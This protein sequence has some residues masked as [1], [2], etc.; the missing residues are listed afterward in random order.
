MDAIA[1]LRQ[2]IAALSA[3]EGYDKAAEKMAEAARDMFMERIVALTPQSGT[4]PY[5]NVKPSIRV[6]HTPIIEGW[7]SRT[8]G[9]ERG[10]R[11]SISNTS[12]HVLA[13]LG[14]VGKTTTISSR[15]PGGHL[16]FWWGTSG[17][18]GAGKSWGPK[19]GDEPG[20]YTF[21]SVEHPGQAANPFL[22][23]A[24]K[25]KRPNVR[26]V[27][28][29]GTGQYVTELMSNSGLRRIA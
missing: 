16:F 21:L 29:S 1:K 4:E 25:E 18:Y 6:G 17:D 20:M 19:K 15:T 14:G 26:E 28:K 3:L 8:E 13:V 9:I 24:V 27:V 7:V 2:V 10:H 22:P 5:Y 11:L 12:Q 23:R